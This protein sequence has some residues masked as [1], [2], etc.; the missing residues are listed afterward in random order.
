MSSPHSQPS[1]L[2]L[3]TSAQDPLEKVKLYKRQMLKSD[4]LGSF[5]TTARAAARQQPQGQ[6]ST[7]TLWNQ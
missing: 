5:V 3:S 2:N 4:A 7:G 1:A 6:L